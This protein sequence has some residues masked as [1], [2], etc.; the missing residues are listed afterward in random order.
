MLLFR[1]CLIVGALLNPL[2]NLYTLFLEPYVTV[3]HLMITV[4]TENIIEA[5]W[6]HVKVSICS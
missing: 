2:P 3:V 5:I 6:K 1:L 4:S